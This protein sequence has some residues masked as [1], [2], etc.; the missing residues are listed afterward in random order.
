MFVGYIVAAAGCCRL[1]LDGLDGEG[2]CDVSMMLGAAA[3]FKKPLCGGGK[4]TAGSTLMIPAAFNL[5][6]SCFCCSP[7]WRFV[8]WRSLTLYLLILVSLLLLLVDSSFEMC[9]LYLDG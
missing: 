8:D 2:R 4:T 1:L 3:A 7:V 6:S 5:L 9:L